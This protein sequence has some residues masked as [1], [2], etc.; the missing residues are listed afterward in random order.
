[1]TDVPTGA[2]ASPAKPDDRSTLTSAPKDSSAQTIVAL[3]TVVAVT[4]I[5]LGA[6]IVAVV[7]KSEVAV[8]TAVVAIPSV[9]VGGL[10]N[11][12]A[13]PT[14]IAQARKTPDAQPSIGCSPPPTAAAA[15]DPSP[16]DQLI[17]DWSMM[18][19]GLGQ[20]FAAIIGALLPLGIVCAIGYFEL[21]KLYA[22]FQAGEAAIALVP[23]LRQTI[24][25]DGEALKDQKAECKRTESRSA[26]N[27]AL[28]SKFAEVSPGQPSGQNASDITELLQ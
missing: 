20:F 2:A 4:I 19:Q 22:R 17:S 1:M 7:C 23:A 26:A 27:R 14:G 28:I 9:V 6:L 24:A 12:L 5:A 25:D 18:L 21:P 15:N 8:V 16:I 13:S 11:S 10:L 3:I